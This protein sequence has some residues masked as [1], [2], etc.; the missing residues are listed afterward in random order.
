[1]RTLFATL[2]LLVS[3]PLLAGEAELSAAIV[4]LQSPESVLIDVR[5]ADEFAA[6]ALPGAEQIDYEQM[7]SRI[8]TIAPDKDTPI[9]LYCRSGR[10]S[11]IA[12][13]NLRAMGYSNLINA[14]G[15]DE[16]K[17]ALESQD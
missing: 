13:E 4:A 17:M 12:E 6:G 5:S 10:R 11:G 14:G 7:A 1:M 15:Y 16:L 2:G 3:L 8:N 9:I